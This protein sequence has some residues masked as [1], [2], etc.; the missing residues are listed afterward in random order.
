MRSSK[1]NE[2]ITTLNTIARKGNISRRTVGRAVW[3]LNQRETEYI[4]SQVRELIL[5]GDDAWGEIGDR[6][7]WVLETFP[8]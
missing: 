1:L 3:A 4:Y 6:I 8:I 2:T 5:D 7:L